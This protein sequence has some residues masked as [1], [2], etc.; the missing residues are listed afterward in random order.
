MDHM[1]ISGTDPAKQCSLN[2]LKVLPKNA[3]TSQKGCRNEPTKLSLSLLVSYV[4]CN[5][6]DLQADW[7]RSCTYGR[8]PNAR[9]F[10]GFFNVPVLRRHGTTLSDTPPHSVAF[11]DTLGIRRRYSR[12][13]PRRPH[14]GTHLI[15]ISLNFKHVKFNALKTLRINHRTWLRV[16]RGIFGPP[17]VTLTK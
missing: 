1:R 14:G 13:E 15:T 6:T 10:A 8:A 2:R 3:K 9:Y 4:T 7:R 17:A 5:G 16:P 11:Y 12:L